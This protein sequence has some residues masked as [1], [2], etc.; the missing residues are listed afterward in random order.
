MRASIN[1]ATLNVNG[2]AAQNDGSPNR[3]WKWINSTLNEN[4]I[5]ILALQE[6]H[7]DDMTIECLHTMYSHKMEII[8]SA[9]PNS[10]RSTAGVAFIINKSLIAPKEVRAHELILGRALLIR[11]KWLDSEE[12][13]LLNIYAPTDKQIH[14]AFWRCI[15]ERQQEKRLPRPDFMLGDFNI[16][17]DDID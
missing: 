5:A 2:L 6:T 3:K 16:T 7:L 1:I 17:E 10:P 14:P 11:I 13:K 15:Q 12:T 9:D 4:K 8:Y